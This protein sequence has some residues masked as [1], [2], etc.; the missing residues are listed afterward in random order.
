LYDQRSVFDDRAADRDDARTAKYLRP[1]LRVNG[2][3]KQAADQ[4]H[5]QAASH[6]LA[7]LWMGA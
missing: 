5:E 6:S 4:Q 2:Y 3:W 1:F 7:L